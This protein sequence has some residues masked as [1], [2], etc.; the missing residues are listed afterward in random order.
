M[1]IA[2]KVIELICGIFQQATTKLGGCRPGGLMGIT[3]YNYGILT[4]ISWHMV[5]WGPYNYGDISRTYNWNCTS[6]RGSN[7]P[8]LGFNHQTWGFNLITEWV[9]PT[10]QCFFP[11][12][13]RNSM[14]M[15]SS[16]SF[17]LLK[18]KIRLWIQ[19]P[20]SWISYQTSHV[21]HPCHSYGKIIRSKI[22][23]AKYWIGQKNMSLYSVYVPVYP[24]TLIGLSRPSPAGP[25]CFVSQDVAVVAKKNAQS[26]RVPSW[27][28]SDFPRCLTG[29]IHHQWIGLFGKV[30]SPES[31]IFFMGKPRWENRFSDSLILN[32]KIDGFRFSDSPIA[33]PIHWNHW[34]QKQV[35]ENV[36]PLV[37]NEKLTSL[38]KFQVAW[39]DGVS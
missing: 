29:D 20:I 11:N 33:R 8:A 32:G 3:W 19:R 1:F 35:A 38:E 27:T 15:S 6:K 34:R 23:P 21:L 7:H 14:N 12:W 10:G 28:S 26:Q 13:S 24:N 5:I 22:V 30:V 31:L 16:A 4:S 2:G 37:H 25:S 36:W 39:R 9:E 18:V 17:D